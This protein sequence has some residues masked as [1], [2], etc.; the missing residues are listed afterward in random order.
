MASIDAGIGVPFDVRVAGSR[1]GP[2]FRTAAVEPHAAPVAAWA[3]LAR[4]SAGDN[5]FFHP[6]FALPAIG[7]LDRGVEILTVAA[8]SGSLAAILPFTE[9]RLGRI[10]PAA[11]IWTHGYAPL[12]LPL[13]HRDGV[14]DVIE[15]LVHGLAVNRSLVVPDLPLDGPV[16][17]AF[18][19]IAASE[20]RPLTVLDRHVRAVLDRDA[21]STPDGRQVR[22]LADE[23]AVAVTVASTPAD[24]AAAFEAFVVLEA[25][26][27]NGRRAAALASSAPVA[28]FARRAVADAAAAGTVRV[29]TLALDG[30]PIAS[31]ICLLSGA[32]AFIWKIAC[33]EAYA[34]LAP[35]AELM[36]EFAP[37]LFAGEPAITRID[38]CATPDRHMID[39]LWSGRMELGTLVI[40]PPGG[41][42][43]HE[44]GLA[45][46]KAERRIRRVVRN[47][48]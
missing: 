17:A 29:A 46:E 15:A 31:A 38:S 40:G 10:A 28:A 37:R 34:R 41:G 44:A 27:W 18:A 35:A 3:D 5:P 8:R 4:R 26:G 21:Q 2:K 45:A 25:S 9:A 23:G 24:V 43:V 42:I 36:L 16:A 39:Q 20:G 14:A 12:G 13:V 19:A 48:R 22:P 32:T 1:P 30:R 7:S 47:P 6:D 33:D 11:R